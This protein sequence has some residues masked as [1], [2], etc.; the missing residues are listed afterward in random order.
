MGR[1]TAE[2]R[3]G[4]GEDDVVVHRSEAVD[5]EEAQLLAGEDYEQFELD[6]ASRPVPTPQQHNPPERARRR[7]GRR[8]LAFLYG[9]D[10]PKV[11]TISP[12]FPSV[13][14]LPVKWLRKMLPRQWQ[15]RVLLALFLLAWAASL[16]V[17]LVLSKGTATDASGAVLAHVDCVDTLWRRNNE[18]GLDGVDCRPF[19]NSSF[20]FRCPADCAGVRVLNPHHVGPQDVNYRPLVI[21]GGGGSP[22]RGD[23]FL[24]GAAIH[25]GVISDTSGGCGV[26]T[27]TG[28]YYQYFPSAQ[29]GIAS[30]PFDSHFP[31]SFTVTGDPAIR[32]TA[33]DPRWTISLPLSILF[34]TLLS[35][36]TTS[37]ALLYFATFLGIFTHVALVSDPPAISTPSSTLLL[38]TLVSRYAEHLLPSLFI[39]TL[40]YHTTARRSLSHLAPTAALSKTR[41]RG[42]FAER[43]LEEQVF[44][45]TR[46]AGR[47]ADEYFRFGFLAQGGRALDYG[48]AGTW[49]G[50]GTWSQGAGFY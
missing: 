2:H 5:D 19:S 32:C 21:G 48:E 41:F 46:E 50:N 16:A 8:W 33:P 7:P 44:A 9:P 45:W 37:P 6:D 11:Y 24:C 3:D 30:I 17:P 1:D 36:L 49:F 40:I 25:A 10:P 34:T 18:C 12:F 14:E 27:L 43:P 39:A 47:A 26:V 20:A 35:L 23:S 38:P 42:W 31:L 13:Q 22:Y 28:E 4:E 29:H 15:R